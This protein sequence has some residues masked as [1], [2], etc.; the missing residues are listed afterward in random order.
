MSV[1]SRVKRFFAQ[2]IAGYSEVMNESS[3]DWHLVAKRMMYDIKVFNTEIYQIPSDNEQA[4]EVKTPSECSA[5]ESRPSSPNESFDGDWVKLGSFDFDVNEF[6][7][8]MT[9]HS[10]IKKGY[11]HDSDYEY[12]VESP[13]ALDMKEEQLKPK[14]TKKGRREV[15]TATS[16]DFTIGQT[17]WEER[18]RVKDQML[19]H[20]IQKVLRDERS[21][22][23]DGVF[24][25]CVKNWCGELQKGLVVNSNGDFLLMT[26][27]VVHF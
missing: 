11:D 5:K 4:E 20:I 6:E 1:V 19:C 9:N 24:Y 18:Y 2:T 3:P 22:E 26:R 17:R 21:I 7:S 15:V 25:K 10:P 27:D 14:K 13:N 8:E 16:I 23:Y 12:E